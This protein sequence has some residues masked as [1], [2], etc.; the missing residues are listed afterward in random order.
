MDLTTS[1]LGLELEHP[2]MPGASPLADDLDM[3][4]RLEDAGA[5]AITLRSLF[6]E[7]IEQEQVATA[8]FLDAPGHSFAEALSYLPA[9]SEF[10]LGPEEYLEQVRR[11]RPA[12]MVRKVPFLDS[13]Q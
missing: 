1:Y 5:A 4:K 8:D 12:R 13:R 7:Q 6:E 2:F 11:I 10:A 3:V 9:P